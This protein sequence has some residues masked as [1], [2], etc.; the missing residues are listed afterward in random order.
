VQ[1]VATR[2]ECEAAL[3]RLVA[4]LAEVDPALKRGHDSIERSVSCRVPDLGTMWTGQLRDG[5][6]HE[7]TEREADAQIRLTVASDDLVAL[8]SGQLSFASAW[9]SGRLKVSAGVRDMLRL[10]TLL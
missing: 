4:K 6:L 2:E 1:V 3:D 7:V 9:A 5:H 8:T 10:R